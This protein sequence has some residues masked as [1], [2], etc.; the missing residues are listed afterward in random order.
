MTVHFHYNLGVSRSDS[1][2]SL[3]SVWLEYFKLPEIFLTVVLQ[4][5]MR[6]KDRYLCHLGTDMFRTKIVLPP[7][8]RMFCV[9]CA[10]RSITKISEE[11]NICMRNIARRPMAERQCMLHG[12][13]GAGASEF[14]YISCIYI[15]VN[16]TPLFIDFGEVPSNIPHFLL[17][18]GPAKQHTET[19]PFL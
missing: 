11:I 16:F 19:H 1:K 7:T 5:Y 8:F 15:G 9:C 18:G 3:K 17:F 12:H 2:R 6:T 14:Q 13:T 4:D 10:M